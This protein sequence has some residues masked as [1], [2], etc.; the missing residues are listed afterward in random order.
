MNHKEWNLLKYYFHLYFFWGLEDFYD[1][2]SNRIQIALCH[3]S[4]KHWSLWQD[5][6][7][8]HQMLHLMEGYLLWRLSS[9]ADRL[10]L[11]SC[12]PLKVFCYRASSSIKWS[13]KI[14]WVC[15]L[16]LNIRMSWKYGHHPCI[17]SRMIK[18][19]SAI[20]SKCC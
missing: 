20:S 1:I 7:I 6:I 15:K 8:F 10:P 11:K 4:R 9:I 3:L 17:L 13:S 19:W 16:V 12:P 2:F 14:G 5:K 18:N